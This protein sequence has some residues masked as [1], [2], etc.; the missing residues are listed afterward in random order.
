[1][2]DDVNTCS[3]IVT[4]TKITAKFDGDDENTCSLMVQSWRN[5]MVDVTTCS[6]IVKS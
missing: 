3:L 2:I 4:L 6:L 5:L 1:M